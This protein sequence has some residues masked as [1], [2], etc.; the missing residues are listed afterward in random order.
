[1]IKKSDDSGSVRKDTKI[2][3]LEKVVSLVLTH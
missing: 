3:Q 2:N 1:M